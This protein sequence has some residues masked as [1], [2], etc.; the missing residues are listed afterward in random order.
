MNVTITRSLEIDRLLF[1]GMSRQV[2][3]LDR[4]VLDMDFIPPITY[5]K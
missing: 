4:H 3:L 2:I 5:K 1:E